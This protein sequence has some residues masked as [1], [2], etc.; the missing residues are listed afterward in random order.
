MRKQYFKHIINIFKQWNKKWSSNYNFYYEIKSYLCWTAVFY[1]FEM[2]KCKCNLKW[3][4]IC[5]RFSNSQT[6]EQWKS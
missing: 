5:I 3:D 4:T 1:L 6:K 2:W